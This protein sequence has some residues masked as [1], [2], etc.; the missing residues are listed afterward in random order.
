V[1]FRAWNAILSTW[2]FTRKSLKNMNYGWAVV[3]KVLKKINSSC[4][5]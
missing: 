2:G 3:A 4:Y 1:P 5:V